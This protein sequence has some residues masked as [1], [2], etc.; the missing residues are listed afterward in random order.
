MNER[1]KIIRK[2][3]GLSQ[4]EFG[5][6]IGISG[7]AVAKLESGINNPSDQTIKLIC[8]TYDISFLWLKENIGQMI[9][10]K[11]TDDEM[12]DRVMLNTSDFGKSIMKAFAK[13]ADEE[14]WKMLA[15][16]VKSMENKS[17]KAD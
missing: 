15:M 11:D 2:K 7:P 1:I 5:R 3:L 14:D 10:P 8:S 17:K 9:L 12:I 4:T 6:R 13:V 16:I